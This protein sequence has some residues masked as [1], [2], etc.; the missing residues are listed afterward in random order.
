M[1]FPLLSVRKACLVELVQA[2]DL[3]RNIFDGSGGIDVGPLV[4]QLRHGPGV[5]ADNSWPATLPNGDDRTVVGMRP[6]L[7]LHPM[8]NR[9]DLE[10]IAKHR[11]GKGSRRHATPQ[12]EDFDVAVRNVK[13]AIDDDNYRRQ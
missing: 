4:A 7:K 10:D 6:L 12:V 9:N 13:H 2:K 3:A 5:V 8:P 11:K 1:H